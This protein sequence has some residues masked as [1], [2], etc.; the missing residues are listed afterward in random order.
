MNFT[1][2]SSRHSTRFLLPRFASHL[3]SPLYSSFALPF[4]IV[5]Q[6]SHGSHT[7][8]MFLSISWYL[9]ISWTLGRL[10]RSLRG[11]PAFGYLISGFCLQ[12]VIDPMWLAAKPQVQLL[13]FL[14]VLIRAGLE[15]SPQDMHISTICLGIF[16]IMA[17][18]ICITGFAMSYFDRSFVPAA[19][20]AFVMTPMG[21]L[22]GHFFQFNHSIFQASIFEI[23]YFLFFVYQATVWFC[24][25]FKHSSLS[26]WAACP[27]SCSRLRRWK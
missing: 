3:G 27:K 19:M 13:A 15:I 22:R 26:S 24:L 21:T 23:I 7:I 20:L 1:L 8:P 16:P 17:D 9:V 18:V 2:L 11:P 5:P 12:F 14:I 6:E 4:A 25:L 10:V